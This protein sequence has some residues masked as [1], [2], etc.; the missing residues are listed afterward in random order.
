[1][2]VTFENS[3]FRLVQPFVPAGDQPKAIAQLTEG[4]NLGLQYQTLLGVTGSGKTYTMAQVIARLGRPALVL[5]HNK[6]L[7]AQ[8]YSEFRE[9]FPENAVEYFVSY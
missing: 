1:M 4:V 3:P 5:A 6:T 2:L 8:L 9:F 7:A